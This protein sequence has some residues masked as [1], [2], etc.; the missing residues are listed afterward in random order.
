MMRSYPWGPGAERR[1]WGRRR[2]PERRGSSPSTTKSLASSGWIPLKFA[3]RV[4]LRIR[5]S[6]VHAGGDGGP[7]ELFILTSEPT[8]PGCVI[9]VRPMTRSDSGTR[10][11]K[12]SRSFRSRSVRDVKT[13]HPQALREIEECIRSDMVLEGNEKVLGDGRAG[14]PRRPRSEGSEALPKRAGAIKTRESALVGPFGRLEGFPSAYLSR[15]FESGSR[16]PVEP[17]R[18]PFVT[19]IC[20]LFPSPRMILGPPGS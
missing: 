20:E 12:T 9:D 13:V 7:L 2:S 11:A 17:L 8:S 14:P 15:A 6:D 19:A 10:K 1:Q 4:P 5:V 18:G 16:Y 3:R